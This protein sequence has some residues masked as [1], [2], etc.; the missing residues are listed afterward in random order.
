MKAL[1]ALALVFASNSAFADGFVC[2][3]EFEAL[4][5]KVYNHTQASRGT[6]NAAVMILADTG[7]NYGNKTIAK[8]TDWNQTLS[9]VGTIYTAK[10]D[11]RFLD[12]GREGELIAGTKIGNLKTI[13]LDVDF[14]YDFPAPEGTEFRGDL[15]L[16]KRSGGKI[17]VAMVCSRYLKG[18]K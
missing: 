14:S 18:A 3:N 12:S 16:L 1:L 2:Y 5:V 15:T 11:H 10:V 7:I 6:R 17:Q 8:F 13:E 9:N 4:E